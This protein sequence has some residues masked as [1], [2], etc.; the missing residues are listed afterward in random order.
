MICVPDGPVLAGVT[1]EW[2]IS[3]LRAAGHD[4]SCRALPPARIAEL[5]SARPTGAAMNSP[6]EG[7][8][9]MTPEILVASGVKGVVP[10]TLAAGDA[11]VPPLGKMGKYLQEQY[12]DL[13]QFTASG[14]ADAAL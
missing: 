7:L 1:L 13:V 10:A 8:H 11:P 5:E 14:A 3:R 9:P 6:R 2:A 4:V 12:R